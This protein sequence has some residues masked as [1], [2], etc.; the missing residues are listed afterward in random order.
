MTR[1]VAAAM[2]SPQQSRRLSEIKSCKSVLLYEMNV[3]PDACGDLHSMRAQVLGSNARYSAAFP[4]LLVSFFPLLDSFLPQ[5]HERS[6]I[7]LRS[8]LR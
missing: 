8:L 4:G 2:S 6:H 1:K 7:T 3:V 5:Q